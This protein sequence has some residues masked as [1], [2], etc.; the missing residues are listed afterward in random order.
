MASNRFLS[1]RTGWAS[2]C[3]LLATL[4]VCGCR[5]TTAPDE[6]EPAEELAIAADDVPR[7]VRLAAGIALD[8]L[9]AGA[10]CRAFSWDREDDMWECTVDGL[11]FAAEPDLDRNGAFSEFEFDVTL[12]VL[13][14]HAPELASLIRDTCG[15]DGA[16]H[17]ETSIRRVDLLGPDPSFDRLWGE[18]AIF[19]EFQCADGTDYEVDAYGALVI[20]P[21]DDAEA[22]AVADPRVE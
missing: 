12:D 15:R 14:H 6:T 2:S 11:A 3:A 7:E 19:V 20:A 1:T 9:E 13:D 4:A 8:A 17:V 22:P 21:D 16:A 5:G 18:D 10:E